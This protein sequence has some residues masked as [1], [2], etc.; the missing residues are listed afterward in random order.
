MAT[1]GGNKSIA[2]SDDIILFSDDTGLGLTDINDLLPKI[3]TYGKS[4]NMGKLLVSWG[5]YSYLQIKDG[6][7][8]MEK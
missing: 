3:E 4:A 5:K 2:H 1:H 8:I 7:K 6:S